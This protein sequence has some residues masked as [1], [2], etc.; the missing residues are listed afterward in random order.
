VCAAFTL[1]SGC[2]V[3]TECAQSRG[4]PDPPPIVLFKGDAQRA[5]DPGERK[6]DVHPTNS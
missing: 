5:R 1:F 4:W 6:V 3:S 2:S